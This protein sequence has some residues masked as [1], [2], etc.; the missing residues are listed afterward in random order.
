VARAVYQERDIYLM[1]DPISAL[2]ASV[3]KKLFYNVILDHLRNKT[4]V[5]VTHAI[6]FIH[7]ADKIYLMDDGK[8]AAQG[9]YEDIKDNFKLQYLLEINNKNNGSRLQESTP[10]RKEEDSDTS[11]INNNAMIQSVTQSISSLN[12]SQMKVTD[13]PDQEK[14]R[15]FE[16]LGRVT[17]EADGKIIKDENEEVIDVTMADYMVLLKTSGGWPQIIFLQ[18][19][20][21]GFTWCKI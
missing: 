9:S 1:D 15:I 20:M 7:L 11:M 13:I 12:V 17:K 10:R 2:D 6:D 19:I 21:I 8:I 4:V 5:L 18:L 14:L 3:R 16:T